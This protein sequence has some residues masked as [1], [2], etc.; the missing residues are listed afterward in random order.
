MY[1]C[2]KHKTNGFCSKCFRENSASMAQKLKVGFHSNS[3]QQTKQVFCQWK[4]NKCKMGWYF[5]SGCGH[6]CK[7]I[8]MMDLKFCPYCRKKLAVQ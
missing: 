5:E 3:T 6:S 8:N 1:R 7:V 2:F 4:S